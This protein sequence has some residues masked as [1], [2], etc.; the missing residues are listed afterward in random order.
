MSSIKFK[1]IGASHIYAII[2]TSLVLFLVGISFL[3][4]IHGGRLVDQFKESIE[5]SIIMN[6][7]TSETSIK[8]LEQKIKSEKYVHD[9]AYVSKEEAMKNYI[10][11]T[12]DNFNEMLG[13]NPLYSSVNIKLD[14]KYA[15]EDSIY[16]IQNKLSKEP[17][18]A[19]FYYEK[20]L[21]DVINNNVKKA[22]IIVGVISLLLLLITVAM[23]DSTIR[24]AM[25][26][27]RF[28][29]RSMQLVGATRW[30]I[31]KPFVGRAIIDGLISSLIAVAA[32][33][34]LLNLI[35]NFIPDLSVLQDVFSTI[36][37]FS[38]VLLTGLSFSII[39]TFFAVRK[40]LKMKLDELY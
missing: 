22:G 1:R 10:A 32:L 21:V 3:I 27:S 30:F 8:L 19:E 24:L 16:I 29:I 18:V 40:Y 14:S 35:L 25:Y 23:I 37:L 17:G 12:G 31:I 28:L 33:A 6:D 9:I 38:L 2:S 7:T 36:T 11:E 34:T 13:Y 20:K 4:F 15:N 39:S 26:S 5:F